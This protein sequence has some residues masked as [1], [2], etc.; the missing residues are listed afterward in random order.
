MKTD[1]RR[2][3]LKKSVLAGASLPMMPP[4]LQAPHPERWKSRLLRQLVMKLDW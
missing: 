4:L 2:G 1:S 3:F